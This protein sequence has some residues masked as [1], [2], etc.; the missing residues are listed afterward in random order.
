MDTIG[1][2]FLKF[3]FRYGIGMGIA[4][5]GKA[6][7]YDGVYCDCCSCEFDSFPAC[8]DICNGHYGYFCHRFDCENTGCISEDGCCPDDCEEFQLKKG[9]VVEDA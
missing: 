6:I 5:V 7:G 1:R 3:M 4:G 9:L 2:D 8:G